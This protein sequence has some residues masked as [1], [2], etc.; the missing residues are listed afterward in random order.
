MHHRHRPD[1][2]PRR[3]LQQDRH[4]PEGARR[5][6]N[7]V[8]FYVALPSSTIDWTIEDGPEIPIEERKKRRS[9]PDR[10]HGGGASRR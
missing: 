10:P 2:R 8:P 9:P 1:H 5:L 6:R 4:L 3:R 7:G